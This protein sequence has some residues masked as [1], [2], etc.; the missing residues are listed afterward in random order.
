MPHDHASGNR[1]IKWL[2]S[3]YGRDIGVLDPAAYSWARVAYTAALNEDPAWRA[4][5]RRARRRKL[6]LFP[7]FTPNPETEPRVRRRFTTVDV[8]IDVD[9]A[10]F[11][12]DEPQ[13][14]ADLAVEH[15]QQFVGLAGERLRLGVAPPWPALPDVPDDL[16][17]YEH[18]D[19]TPNRDEM[20]ELFREMGVKGDVE[21]LLGG[22]GYDE[23]GRPPGRRG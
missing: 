15:I 18:A 9:S 14:L 3:G 4:W 2:H 8:V 19:E 20:R 10:A 16:S 11:S 23:Q 5:W 6:W 17:E 7:L 12:G 13:A 22:F 1:T 21:E